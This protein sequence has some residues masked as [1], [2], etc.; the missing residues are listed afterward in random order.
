MG[1]SFVF[2]GFARESLTASSIIAAVPSETESRMVSLVLQQRLNRLFLEQDTGWCFYAVPCAHFKI[3]V[4]NRKLGR[5]SGNF[6]FP[7]SIALGQC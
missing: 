5:V 3:H 6:L 7:L 4:S 1:Y 2:L